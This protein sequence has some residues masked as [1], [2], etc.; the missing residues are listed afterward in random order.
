M[1][2]GA[3]LLGFVC[4]A[5]LMAQEI[6]VPA[7]PR[8]SYF[9]TVFRPLETN[10]QLQAPVKLRD[11]VVGD[12]LELSLRNYLD[13][14]LSNNT[15]IV[16]QRLQIEQP[17][18]QILRASSIFDPLAIARFNALRR[19][20]PANDALL[21]A[22]LL[23]QLNQPFDLGYQQLLPTGT[24]YNVSFNALRVSNNSSFQL[25]NPAINTGLNV[26]FA[27][28]LLRNRGRFYTRLPV[29]IAQSRLRAAEFN[30]QDQVLRT[31]AQAE[32]A[33][34][35]VI[36]A[37]EN[38]RVQEQSL[39]LSG[40]ALKRA[41]KELELGA[42]SPLEIFQPKAQYATAEIAVTQ[43]RFRLAQT[44]DVLRRQIG[45]DLDADL[46][47]L[48]IVLTEPVE[49]PADATTIDK[50]D[51]V[52]RAYAA[53]P[54]LKQIRQFLDV[55]DL[56]IRGAKNALLPNLSIT[57]QYGSSGRGG[58]AFQRS[59]IFDEAGNR[60]VT[61]IPGGL[62]D[63]FSQMFGF[64]VPTYGFGLS[65]A[66]PI[67]DRRAAADLADATVSK[68]LDTARQR[69]LEQNIRL[70]VLNAI[71]QLESAKASVQLARVALDLAQKRLEADQKRY[72][73]GTTTLFFLLD[74]QAALTRAQSDLVNQSVNYRRAQVNLLQRTGE[75]LPE[76]NITI[77]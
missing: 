73:L 70:E 18:N 76:R 27:Q 40:E 28:P 16:V 35:D 4:S 17:R 23:S 47:N 26:N 72:E 31:I 34:W 74:A 22:N 39:A 30:F 54:D 50:E 55:D 59:N 15:D 60:V 75:L 41:E 49:P 53:R 57:G 21:G 67:R 3:F 52:R 64:G 51:A 69:Q 65:L 37:R 48:P 10:V 12:K 68:K 56:S 71:N 38:L 13:L 7:F 61:V 46:R 32:Q 11:Y 25:F 66:L 8:P 1:R 63:A 77:Q 5:T 19:T 58:T 14:V 20:T 62:G 6:V 45:V 24:Q 29:T 44:E 33:Y 9:R 2:F 42:L 43:A 36:G